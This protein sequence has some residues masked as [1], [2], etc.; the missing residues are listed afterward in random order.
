MA[1]SMNR[2]DQACPHCGE[3]LA[4]KLVWRTLFAGQVAHA[5]PACGKKFRL[6]YAAK[7]RVGYLNIAL[8]LGLTIVLGFAFLLTAAETAR[9]LL[10]YLTLA[11]VILYLLPRQARY[12]QLNAPYRFPSRDQP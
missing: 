5:C 7:V 8:I 3:H 11:G 9:N 2:L 1:P 12:E 10:I 6:T 4:R